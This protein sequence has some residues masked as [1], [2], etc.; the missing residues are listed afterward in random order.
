MTIPNDHRLWA[1]ILLRV[2]ARF[3]NAII[4]GGAIRDNYFNLAPKDI[5][6]F[7]PVQTEEDFVNN[8]GLLGAELHPV[9]DAR[10]AQ[11]EEYDEWEKGHLIGVATVIMHGYEVQLIARRNHVVGA[12]MEMVSK[13]DGGCNQAFYALG[14][15]IVMTED[16]AKDWRERTYTDVV[17]GPWTRERYDRFN[18]RN[19]GVLR[20]VSYSDYL[21]D[22]GRLD[23]V[24]CAKCL[25]PLCICP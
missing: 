4:G 3:P 11:I 10:K 15:P 17:G 19:P 9:H 16:C 20:W 5:D 7:V 8:M 25:D 24:T 18:S 23:E 13:F 6:V 1:S 14:M 22:T 2:H 21:S 12:E